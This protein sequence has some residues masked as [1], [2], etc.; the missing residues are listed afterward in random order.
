MK[1]LS[2][3]ALIYAI[4]VLLFCRVAYL[5]GQSDIKAPLIYHDDVML[6]EHVC[7]S[8]GNYVDVG[9]LP[10]VNASTTTKRLADCQKIYNLNP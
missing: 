8:S 5:Q 7:Y 1:S 4:L 10:I 9:Y 2:L 6:I 3:L